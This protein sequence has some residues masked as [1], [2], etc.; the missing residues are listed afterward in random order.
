MARA[1][2]VRAVLAPAGHAAVDEALVAGEALV[3]SEA[4]PLGDA[5]PVAL[6]EDVGVLHEVEQQLEALGRLEV[7][8]HRAAAAGEDV[9]AGAAHLQAATA[10]GPVDADHVRPEV[11]EHHRRERPR[12]DPGDLDDLD[13]VQHTHA[14]R[15]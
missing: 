15:A 13:A 1:L 9:G 11:G 12:A 6:E 10:G 8:G 3:G 2:G 14:A 5:G 4:E 7:Q